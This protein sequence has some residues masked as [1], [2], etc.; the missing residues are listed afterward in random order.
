M[1]RQTMP[2]R[3]DVGPAGD[4]IGFILW[5]RDDRIGHSR[6]IDRPHLAVC[7]VSLTVGLHIIK[8][9]QLYCWFIC[10][11]LLAAAVVDA[12]S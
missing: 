4:F 3:Q 9:G 2:T 8:A 12:V 11:R 5:H 7:I 6:A 10:C 1:Q